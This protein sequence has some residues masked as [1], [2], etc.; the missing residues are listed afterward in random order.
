MTIDTRNRLIRIAC[1]T[2]CQL[3][4]ARIIAITGVHWWP[5]ILIMVYGAAATGYGATP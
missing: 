4:S 3:A 2:V 1:M 5:C